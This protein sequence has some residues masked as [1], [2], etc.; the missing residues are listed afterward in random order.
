MWTEPNFGSAAVCAALGAHQLAAM[1]KVK[2]KA[3]PKRK[4]PL[5]GHIPPSVESTP[6]INAKVTQ[7]TIS[8]FHVLL[9]RKAQL[10]GKLKSTASSSDHAATAEE[11]E[12]VKTE[13][14]GLG[15]LERYQT[16][17]KLGQGRE[18]GGDSSKVLVEW[19]GELGM[20]IKKDKTQAGKTGGKLK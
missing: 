12:K 8:R 13:M 17:S 6:K 19:L 1:P 15:G 20:G 5:T 7:A 10:Q 9:K 16:M 18:R 3:K 2:S 4:T 11:L 14:E